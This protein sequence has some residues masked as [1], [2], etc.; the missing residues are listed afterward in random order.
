MYGSWPH[1]SVACVLKAPVCVG[2]HGVRKKLSQGCMVHAHSKAR[3]AQGKY[4]THIVRSSLLFSLALSLEYACRR[5]RQDREQCMQHVSKKCGSE[6]VTHPT[7]AW[8]A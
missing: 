7:S 4:R 1:V 3:H 6:H 5:W 2:T 8:A